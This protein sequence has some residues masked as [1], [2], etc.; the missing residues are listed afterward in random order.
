MATF[1]TGST[2]YLGAH[3]AAGLLQGHSE[4][5]NLLIRAKDCREAEMKLWHA[6]QLHLDF[7]HFQHWLNSHI[8]IFLGDITKVR[9]GLSKADYERLVKS[10]DAVLHCAASLN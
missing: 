3:V 5:L 8:Q 6:M 2:G 9:F 1:I 7:P 4:Y 10:T